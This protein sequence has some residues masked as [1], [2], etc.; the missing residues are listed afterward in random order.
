MELEQTLPILLGLAWIT[1]LFSFVAILFFGP[2]MGTHG[3]NAAS[4]ATAAIVCSFVFSLSALL[5]WIGVHG[6]SGGSHGSHHVLLTDSQTVLVA[7]LRSGISPII[8]RPEVRMQVK[9]FIRHTMPTLQEFSQK[10]RTICTTRSIRRIRTVQAR[11]Y[12][13]RTPAIGTRF[14]RWDPLS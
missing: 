11:T 6:M 13:S 10:T 2:R 9:P 14:S 4:V 12:R 7:E 1:P 5:M 3:K 8:N